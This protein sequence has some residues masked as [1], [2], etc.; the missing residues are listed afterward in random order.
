LGHVQWKVVLAKDLRAEVD[1]QWLLVEQ[2]RLEPRSRGGGAEFP[3]RIFASKPNVSVPSD[4][5]FRGPCSFLVFA[6]RHGFHI[7]RWLVL[8]SQTRREYHPT[9]HSICWFLAED[10]PGR[11]GY[12][13]TY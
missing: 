7:P 12:T 5:P 2:N 8:E 11:G 6:Q 4:K 3:H 10:H 1:R 9:T 13:W